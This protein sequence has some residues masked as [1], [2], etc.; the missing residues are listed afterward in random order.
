MCVD[1]LCRVIVKTMTQEITRS[2]PMCFYDVWLKKHEDRDQTKSG[3]APSLWGV[4]QLFF[5]QPFMHLPMRVLG[6]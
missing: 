5:F 6:H 4:V 2:S 3:L 1:I